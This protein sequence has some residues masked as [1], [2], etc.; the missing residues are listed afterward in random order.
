VCP[1]S[2]PIQILLNLMSNAVKFTKRGSI[3]VALRLATEDE[4]EEVARA[5]ATD[6]KSRNTL[7]TPGFPQRPLRTCA[8]QGR[9]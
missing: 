2:P 9:D 7:G 6:S 5:H 4:A 3:S 8:E 1:V